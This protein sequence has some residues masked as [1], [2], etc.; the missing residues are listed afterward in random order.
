MKQRLDRYVSSQKSPSSPYLR[1]I[2]GES[3][4]YSHM[5]LEDF[6]AS[7]SIGLAPHPLNRDQDFY[8]IKPP[9]DL[10]RD[11][12]LF[13]DYQFLEYNMDELLANI[14][15][16]LACFGKAYLEIVTWRDTEGVIQGISFALIKPVVVFR[17]INRTLFVS[18]QFNKALKLYHIEN[19]NL[20]VLRIK[21][22]S[23]S[24]YSLRKL[25]RK[26]N[27]YDFT[28]VGNMSLYP[29]K[30]GFDF[31]EYTRKSE[32]ALLK[33]TR[34]VYWYGRDGRNQHMS[35]S[36]LLYRAAKFKMLRKEFLNYIIRQMNKGLQNYKNEL[37]FN[38]ELIAD[39]AD[40][41][42]MK[43]FDRL[44]SGEIN[45]SQLSKLVFRI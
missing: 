44:W 27:K 5:F 30:T 28:N 12:L 15:Q 21:D 20:I 29:Q 22:L 38:G 19:K 40:F 41:N 31:K 36:Y 14:M 32:F 2:K 23:Y 9:E 33:A 24:R 16:D 4:M 25:L 3:G 1:I 6:C 13:E 11:L 35:E 17:G 42:Y 10:L 34:N 26:I 45:T 7:F 37:G 18:V 8:K 39:C 43:E